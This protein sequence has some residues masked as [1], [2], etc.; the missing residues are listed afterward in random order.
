M[1]RL[2]LLGITGLTR[3]D[4]TV[5]RSVLAQPKRLAFLAYLAIAH[6]VGFRRRDGLLALF[7]PDKD[8]E[9]ARNALRQTI[10]FL[11][12]SLGPDVVVSRGDDEVGIAPDAM[13]T[14]VLEFDRCVARGDRRAALALYGGDLLESFHLGGNAEFNQWLDQERHR[15][16]Q[17]A[18]RMAVEEVRDLEAGEDLPGALEMAREAARL[19]PLHEETVRTLLR[20]LHRSGDRAAALRRFGVLEAALEE[21][22]GVTPSDETA[23][24]VDDIRSHAIAPSAVPSAAPEAP[25]EAPSEAPPEAPS[26]SG[27]PVAV[28]GGDGP[29]SV[30][31]AEDGELGSTGPSSG[32]RPVRNDG[33]DPP[34]RAARRW[35]VAVSTAAGLL[36][37]AAVVVSFLPP[38]SLRSIP[39]LVAVIPFE[40]RTDEY[41]RR[42]DGVIIADHLLRELGKLE[43]VVAVPLGQ[44]RQIL[45]LG[46][47]ADDG[48]PDAARRV[49]ETTGAELVIT[50]AY[51]RAGDDLVFEA[52]VYEPDRRRVVF[53][54]APVR[55]NP[56]DPTTAFEP[57]EEDLFGALGMLLR[58]PR[59][60]SIPMAT[61]PPTYAAYREFALQEEAFRARD[62]PAVVAHGEAAAALD[63]TFF[64][65][66]HRASVGHLNAGNPDGA[67]ALLPDMEAMR[68]DLTVFE[69][70]SLDWLRGR[71]EGD[72][73]K[74]YEGALQMAEIVPTS[75]TMYLAGFM[76]LGVHRPRETLQLLE[77][78]DV[79]QV[80]SYWPDF[81]TV[82]S[83][84]HHRLGRLRRELRLLRQGRERHPD[85][86]GILM[87]E[88]RALAALGRGV[89]V[90]RRM[91]D[92]TFPGSR[93]GMALFELVE[94]LEAHGHPDA[95]A[96]LSAELLRRL[97]ELEADGV[98]RP[99]LGLFRVRLLEAL[100]R[101]PEAL[102]LLRELRV[103]EPERVEYARWW[104]VMAARGGDASAAE[105]IVR[106]L[107][108]QS[109][110]PGGQHVLD[111]AAVAASLGDAERTIHYLRQAEALGAQ[112]FDRLHAD[113]AFS[114]I[115]SDPLFRAYLRPRG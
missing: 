12:R 11:R 35:T 90:D 15:L 48:S 106:W 80:G 25:S 71:L 27:D 77:G 3:A 40:D 44:T 29:T 62:W 63:S 66:R 68:A 109:V 1:T 7:W 55:A 36:L 85:H 95:A 2:Q 96:T 54:T 30:P 111:Q 5:V 43:D 64:W 28:P 51:Y 59:S 74:A 73:R 70:A 108:S 69:R 60:L 20:L 56:D 37:L 78:F 47:V 115:R 94:E 84:A 110:P 53:G 26:A 39:N 24:L 14:D 38:A 22:Y 67:R 6:P 72:L 17:E 101:T 9:R 19:R 46:A 102:A 8:E 99:E 114:P 97:D 21:E 13:V 57:L 41:E 83:S 105:E 87:A 34:H 98:P 58:R 112:A 16:R 75:P 103:R 88:L 23:A 49:A 32:A 18:W 93:A 33:G 10:H 52:T 89:E 81:W 31:R 113:G 82:S 4:G 86:E 92:V 42:H 50:G 45:A 61:R 76:A 100:G 65:A 104:G 79:E 91:A 107:G